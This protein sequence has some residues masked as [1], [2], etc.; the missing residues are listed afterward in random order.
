MLYSTLKIILDQLNSSPVYGETENIEKAM[1]KVK[2]NERFLPP[3]E[4]KE[5]KAT[6]LFKQWAS[7]AE[8]N[9]ELEM[10][11]DRYHIE[12]VHRTEACLEVDVRRMVE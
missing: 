4:V 2:R 5:T 6:V 3:G 7:V 8:G 12:L 9:Y 1:I 11:G 10:G